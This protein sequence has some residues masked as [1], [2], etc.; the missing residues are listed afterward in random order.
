MLRFEYLKGA[1]PS[2]MLI[3]N[4]E[5]TGFQTLTF[6]RGNSF[7]VLTLVR[8]LGLRVPDL[9]LIHFGSVSA[10]VKRVAQ[11][12]TDKIDTHH[13]EQNQRTREKPRP[14]RRVDAFERPLDHVAQAGGRLLDA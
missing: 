14:G 4:M 1:H 12:I 7:Q 6:V 2:I 3:G 13:D 8:Y 5:K 11:A 10:R 9:Y